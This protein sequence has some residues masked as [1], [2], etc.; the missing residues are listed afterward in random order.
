VEVAAVVVAV[1]AVAVVAE[2]AGDEKSSVR[3][4]K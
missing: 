4:H 2:E 1:A 3:K